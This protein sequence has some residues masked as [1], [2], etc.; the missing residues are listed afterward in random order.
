MKYPDTLLMTQ[1]FVINYQIPV[2][3]T[4]FL[5]LK[6]KAGRH[7]KLHLMNS[8]LNIFGKNRSY[9]ITKG[10]NSEFDRVQN[11]RGSQESVIAHLDQSCFQ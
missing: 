1:L 2:I 8:H 3:L 5:L 6:D 10:T 9:H 7:I 4:H 11:T